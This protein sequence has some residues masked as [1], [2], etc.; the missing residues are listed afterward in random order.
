MA[1]CPP[2]PRKFWGLEA[3]EE[4]FPYLLRGILINVEAFALTNLRFYNAEHTILPQ[5]IPVLK[6]CALC[7]QLEA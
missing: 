4:H 1:A 3:S 7:I 2:P 6:Q 5:S